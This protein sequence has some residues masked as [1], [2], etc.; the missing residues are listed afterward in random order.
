[1]ISKVSSDPSCSM[2]ILIPSLLSWSYTCSSVTL[3]QIDGVQKRKIALNRGTRE[4]TFHNCQI[5]NPCMLFG[6]RKQT[7]STLYLKLCLHVPFSAAASLY[8]FPCCWCFIAAFS[9]L[10]TGILC[11]IRLALDVRPPWV[12]CFRHACVAVLDTHPTELVV[13]CLD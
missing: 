11:T 13:A 4:K 9:R 1:M 10:E 3:A 7:A 6:E 5:L 2:K 8:S 12:S